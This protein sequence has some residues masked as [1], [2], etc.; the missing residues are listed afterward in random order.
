MCHDDDSRPPAPP[1]QGTAT[2]CGPVELRSADG[3]AFQAYSARPD[4]PNGRNIVLLPD[5]RGLHP[6]YEH[7]AAA[8]A[9]AGFETVAIDYFGRTAGISERNDE[10]VW[11]PHVDQVES[12]NVEADTAA[13]IEHLRRHSDG[14]V[15]TVGFCFGG[16]QSWRLAAS[17]LD[18]AGS[19]GFYGK[20]A[21]IE[22][23]LADFK[24]P[25]LF[26]VAGA[27][28]STPTEDFEALRN[29]LTDLDK[30]FEMY[31]Y[32]GAPHSFFDRTMSEH[33]AACEDAWQ[34]I[35]TFTS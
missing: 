31:V 8:F 21:L 15:Y 35:L 2:D 32:D 11:R 18:L 3:T 10:F 19:I 28:Q 29:R 27:D 5:V 12:T 1:I 33:A 4:A 34:R 7:L 16:S 25:A 20:P 17:D 9:Q 26:L 24:R 23:V 30:P 6:F 22:D 14:P 13:A